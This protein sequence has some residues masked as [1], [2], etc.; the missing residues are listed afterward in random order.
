MLFHL[1]FVTIELESQ[2]SILPQ[3]TVYSNGDT[4][5]MQSSIFNDMDEDSDDD[6]LDGTPLPPFPESYDEM[7]QNFGQLWIDAT[8]RH[9][10]SIE[11]ASHLWRISFHWMGQILQKK[12]IAAI[13]ANF[14]NSSTYEEKS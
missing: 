12:K 10:I 2:P 1:Y 13:P 6:D 7:L 9:N 5:S 14:H 11:G 4:S 8:V 3:S